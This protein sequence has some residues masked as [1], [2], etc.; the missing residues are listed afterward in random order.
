MV[1]VAHQAAQIPNPTQFSLCRS[2][3]AAV[4]RPAAAS[5]ACVSAARSPRSTASTLQ[6]TRWGGPALALVL[7]EPLD[8]LLD[9]HDRPHLS[10]LRACLLCSVCLTDKAIQWSSCLEPLC[11]PKKVAVERGC[12]ASSPLAA[13]QHDLA[14]LGATI[15]PHS[16]LSSSFFLALVPPLPLGRHSPPPLHHPWRRQP[17]SSHTPTPHP[18]PPRSSPALST[19]T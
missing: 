13:Q 7:A 17:S 11:S 6:P 9:R 15:Q 18:T 16:C 10:R 4:A 8:K 19:L 14:A 2:P 5:R 12:N 3:R 1:Q